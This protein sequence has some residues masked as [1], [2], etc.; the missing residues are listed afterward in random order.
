MTAGP[1]AR[2]G[3]GP[4]PAGD[5]RDGELTESQ[6]IERREFARGHIEPG[7]EPVEPRPAAT[8]V[9]ARPEAAR[10]ARRGRDALEVL[11]LRRPE[12]TRFAAGAYVFPGGVVDA[13]D[14]TAGLEDRFGPEV[15]RAE[16]AALVA[17]LREGFEETGMLPSDERPG[18]RE[19]VRCRQRLL[20]G[21]TD[22]GQVARSLD[23]RFDGLRAVYFARWIT[24]P[25]LSRRYDARFFLAEHRGS[26]PRLIHGE[27]T[28]ALWLSPREALRR[29]EA[30]EL[31]LLYPT[32]KTL[33]DLAERGS[34][35]DAI[36]AY[37]EREVRPVRP[38]L[39]VEGDAVVPVLPGDARYGEAGPHGGRDERS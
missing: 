35:E 23:L 39:L 24:P 22:F 13:A 10:R 4:D 38:R 2:G 26:E 19:R 11:L 14:R 29:F 30:G 7:D 3:A 1:A 8:M 6:R 25:L 16:R 12:E 37:R 28:E 17:A 36:E 32:R 20:K 27:H 21:R 15:T 5:D 31:P 34:L 33:E 18:E 9:F